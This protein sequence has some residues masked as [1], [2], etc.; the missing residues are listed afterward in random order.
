MT[1][2]LSSSEFYGNYYGHRLRDLGSAVVPM[3]RRSPDGSSARRPIMWLVG[4]S[5]VDNKHWLLPSGETMPACN[6]AC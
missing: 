1:G 4:D 5:S 6:G 3:A 2:R